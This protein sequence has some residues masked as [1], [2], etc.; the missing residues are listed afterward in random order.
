MSDLSFLVPLGFIAFFVAMVLWLILS[1]RRRIQ[2][3]R[4][5]A[6]QLGLTPLSSPPSILMERLE[7]LKPA[8]GKEKFQ[9][10]NLFTRRLPDGTLY[11]FDLQT[12][13][14]GEDSSTTEDM[15]LVISSTLNLPRFGIFPKPAAVQQGIASQIYDRIVQLAIS[16][17]RLVM[18]PLS[19]P[20]AFTQAYALLAESPSAVSALIESGVLEQLAA[21]KNQHIQAQGDAFVFSYLPLGQKTGPLAEDNLVNLIDQAQRVLHILEECRPAPRSAY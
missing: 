10:A 18:V 16:R 20:L 1:Q 17:S 9:L 4:Q 2:A 7:Q 13:S 15:L 8:S 14:G 5:R 12:S 11:L 19:S 21:V 6:A 3:K